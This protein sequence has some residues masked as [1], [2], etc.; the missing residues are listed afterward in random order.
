MSCSPTLTPFTQQLYER[1]NW[2]D[3]QLKKIQFYLSEDIVLSR[4]VGM[5]ES[6]IDKGA[7]KIENGRQV[8][9][10]IFKKGTPGVFV[11]SPKDNKF[12]ISFEKEDSKYL[13]FGPNPKMS[14]RYVLMGR[15]WAN[16][17]GQI[18]YN[19]NYF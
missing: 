14:E 13:M 9:Q 2:N 15:D 17:Q 18:T 1:H 6:I 8:E 4:E 16:G 11:F 5:N 19:N 10:V 12:G 3:A 7:I